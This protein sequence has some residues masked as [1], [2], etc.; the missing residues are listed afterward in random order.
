MNNI[1]QRRIGVGKGSV[2]LANSVWEEAYHYV[3]AIIYGGFGRAERTKVLQLLSLGGLA[4][5]QEGSPIFPLTADF[6]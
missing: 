3:G 1:H 6:E 4:A 2:Q 5:Q